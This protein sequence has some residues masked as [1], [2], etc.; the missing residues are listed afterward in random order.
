MGA[1]RWTLGIAVFVVGVAVPRHAAAQQIR[2]ESVARPWR[3]LDFGKPRTP[4]VVTADV[5][6]PLMPHPGAHTILG[7]APERSLESDK[8][9][10]ACGPALRAAH[11]GPKWFAP[12]LPPLPEVQPLNW[13][14]FG[15][16]SQPLPP[17][18]V[19]TSCKG[20]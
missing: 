1:R 19:A 3:T 5:V 14:V 7:A 13:P 18:R 12:S 2:V 9:P 15:H 10:A 11:T 4:P 8:S 20:S 16:R 17:E 6:K